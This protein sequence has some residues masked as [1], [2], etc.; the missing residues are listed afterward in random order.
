MFFGRE[1]KSFHLFSEPRC[2][3]GIFF[4][5]TKFGDPSRVCVDATCSDESARTEHKGLPYFMCRS[6]SVH[7][8]PGGRSCQPLRRGE[9]RR[10]PRTSRPSQTSLVREK[11][12]SRI[13]NQQLLSGNVFLSE[14]CSSPVWASRPRFMSSPQEGAV[15]RAPRGRGHS[16]TPERTRKEHNNFWNKSR[17][18]SNPMPRASSE[19]ALKGPNVTKPE[20]TSGKGLARH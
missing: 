8:I 15:S 19:Q 17:P 11:S 16:R 1:E 14:I 5:K 13:E 9:T 20:R 7:T 10:S 3:L 6:R 2:K 18:W 4:C 12:A